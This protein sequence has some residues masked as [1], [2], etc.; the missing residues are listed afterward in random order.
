MWFYRGHRI[1][2]SATQTADGRWNAEARVRRIVSGEHAHVNHVEC[3]EL[4]AEAAEA[5]AV[6]YAQ[7]WIDRRAVVAR[8]GP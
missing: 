1:D 8:G 6:I 7:R 5:A 3:R 2:V 4:T